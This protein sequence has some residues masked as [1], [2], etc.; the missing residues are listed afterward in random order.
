MTDGYYAEKAKQGVEYQDFIIDQ[1]RKSDPCFIII[2]YSSRE[3]QYNKGESANGYEIKFDNRVDET[4]KL[5]IEVAEKTS[6]DKAEYTP[7]G[8]MRDDNTIFYLIGNYKQA[9]L[10]VKKQLQ[11]TYIDKDCWPMYG[12]DEREN[13]RKTSKGMRIPLSIA[14][15][16][17]CIHEF[18]FG[19]QHD[20]EQSKAG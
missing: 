2:P 19:G 18:N 4:K 17:L 3:Y 9:W 20:R 15:S 10:F 14:K 1:L 7:S 13:N 5:W 16:R 11:A 6:P 12:I 8:I